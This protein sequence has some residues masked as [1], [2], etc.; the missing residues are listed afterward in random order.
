MSRDGIVGPRDMKRLELAYYTFRLGEAKVLW[1][2]F[3]CWSFFVAFYD[4]QPICGRSFA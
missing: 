3:R 2:D 1:G 4:T